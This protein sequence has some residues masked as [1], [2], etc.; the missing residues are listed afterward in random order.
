MIETPSL[1]TRVT[2]L[3][4]GVV[5]ALVV[6]LDV[7]VYLSLRDR[8]ADALDEVL[9]ARTVLVTGLA[10]EIDDPV[11]LGEELAE[12]GVPSRIIVDG[13][14]VARSEPTV[15]RFEEVPPSV[16]AGEARSASR[17]VDLGDGAVAEVLVSRAGVEATLQRVLAIELVGSAAAIGLALVL[18]NRAA[19]IITRPLDRMVATAGRIADG[20]L[21]ERL[22]PTDPDTELGRMAAAFDRMIDALDDAV[23]EARDAEARSRRFLADAAHQLRTPLTGLRASAETLLANPDGPDRDRMAANVA[24]EAAR[25]SRLVSSLLRVARLDRGEPLDQQPTDLC[26]LLSSELDRQQSLAPGIAFTLSTPPEA[27]ATMIT[28]DPDAIR[29]AVANLLDNA[30]RHARTAVTVEV[31]PEFGAVRVLVD[32]DG[33]GVPDVVAD[34][35][36]DRFV[37]TDGGSGLGLPIARGIVQAHG[38][39]LVWDRDRFVL[40]LPAVGMQAAQR[41]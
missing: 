8:L 5:I 14:E 12:L 38:G 26:A 37:S 30:R 13:E 25:L 22:D 15:R 4:V 34:T 6:A 31:R 19:G 18:L 39:R 20:D 35:L 1:R 29:E 3:T 41:P 23:T 32:D 2:V 40:T 17:S 24:R 9:E 28:C 33:P 11:R 21:E 16:D 7:F 10:Q 27:R 36:F